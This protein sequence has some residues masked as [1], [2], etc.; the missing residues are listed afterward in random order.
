MVA[1]VCAHAGFDSMGC[2]YK[3]ACCERTSKVRGHLWTGL[4]NSASSLQ[5]TARLGASHATFRAQSWTPTKPDPMSITTDTLM[6]RLQTKR[7]GLK[8]D[9]LTSIV[10]TS[11]GLI[12][13]KAWPL[14]CSSRARWLASCSCMRIWSRVR[15]PY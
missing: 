10:S 1:L 7:Q 3:S 14:N 9:S 15:D 13:Y 5:I 8:Q 12:I 6:A 11:G 4:R 2:G